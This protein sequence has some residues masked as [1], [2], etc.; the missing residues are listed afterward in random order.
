MITN[1]MWINPAFSKQKSMQPFCKKCGFEIT[2]KMRAIDTWNWN[3]K[4]I[5]NKV[6]DQDCLFS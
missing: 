6:Y 3:F 5:V 4:Q 2:Y 1:K